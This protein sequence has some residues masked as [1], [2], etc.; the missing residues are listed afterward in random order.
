MAVRHFLPSDVSGVNRLHRNVWWPERSAEGWRWLDDNPARQALDA[1]A[2]WVVE[3]ADGGPAAFLGNFIQCFWS[4]DR[5]SYGATGFSVIVPPGQKGRSRDLIGAFVAQPG[6]F[7]RYTLNANARSSPLYQRFGML[8]WP[9]RTHAL[10]LSWIINPAA[11]LYSRGLR[12]LVAREPRAASWLGEQLMPPRRRARS[13]DTSRLPDG[14]SM[15]DDLSEASPYAGFWAALRDQGRLTA[16]RSPAMLRWR[17]S[18]PDLTVRP[19]HLVR[20]LKGE[21]TGHALALL[22]KGNPIEPPTLEIL[23]LEALDRDRGAIS[24]LVAALLQLAPALGAAKVRLQV[25][26]EDTMRDLGDLARKA[27]REGGWGHCH[28][29]FTSGFEGAGDWRPTPFDGDYSFCV[30]PLPLRRRVATSDRPASSQGAP[31]AA[32]A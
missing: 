1:P 4:G 5:R 2:G 13:A 11:C 28:V 20:S 9:P 16:D 15:L 32:R 19:L 6:C 17:L 25:V 8:A 3:D 31:S 23:D 26:T 10:K 22:G 29:A 18:D 12:A 27:R 14:V 30:R 21:I 24:A 7:A